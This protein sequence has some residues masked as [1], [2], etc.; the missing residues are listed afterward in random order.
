MS[1]VDPITLE[2]VSNAL[3]STADVMAIGLYRTAYSTIVRDALDFSTSLCNAEGEQIAQSTTIPFHMGSVPDAIQSMFRK[4]GDAIEPGDVFILNDPFDGGMHI[5]D[6]FIIKPVFVGDRRVAFAVATAHHLDLGGR[7]PG[8]S[9]CDNRDIF[10]DGFRIPM[11]KLYHRGEPDEALFALLRANIRVPVMT[12]GDLR[13]QLSACHVGEHAVLELIERHGIETF[14]SCAREV[15]DYSE[16]LVRREIASWPDGS[17]TFVDYIDSDGCGGPRTKIQCTMTVAGDTLTADLT[18]SADQVPGAINATRSF[19]V[20]T[21]GFAMRSAMSQVLPNTEGMFRPLEVIAPEGSIFNVRMP[22]ASSMR[23]VV[24]FRLADVALGALAGIVPDRIP[25]ACEGGN[26]LVIFGGQRLESQ[27]AYVYYELLCGTWGARPDRDGNDGLCSPANVAANIPIEEAECNYPIRI[28]R[29]GL[30]NDSG[31]AGRFRGGMAVERELTLLEGEA[32]LTIRSDRRDHPPYGLQGG[33][34]GRGSTN[35]LRH[36][37][38]KEVLMTMVSTGI[39][40]GETIYH[41]QPG[42]GGFGDPLERDPKAVARDVRNDRVSREAAVES[43]G[44]M[45]KDG[46]FEVDDE[47]TA[48]LRAE[49]SH[50]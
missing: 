14:E 46:S 39:K 2:I 31:G 50:G 10:Q 6:I 33:Q 3:A 5:P 43:Y 11:L 20:A 18:G 8:S 29:Y 30:V 40:E 23:G 48:R 28:E 35:V 42:G 19:T 13:S 4:Y 17:S 1:T 38:D 36:A 22:G 16:R 32:Q 15:L 7:V 27:D 44:V 24:G 25:A 34:P 9:A 12:F 47:T 49:R 41:R 21:I 45:L 37:A 26:S